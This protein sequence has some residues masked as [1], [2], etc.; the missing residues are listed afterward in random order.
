[1]TLLDRCLQ[2]VICNISVAVWRGSVWPDTVQQ[3]LSTYLLRPLEYFQG[4]AAPVTNLTSAG[5]RD[6]S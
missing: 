3:Q 2:T 4:G 5:A 6:N 1:M